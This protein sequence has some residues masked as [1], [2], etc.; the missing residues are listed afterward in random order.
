MSMIYYFEF[1]FKHKCLSLSEGK[2]EGFIK[3]C[4]DEIDVNEFCKTG[5]I[6]DNLLHISKTLQNHFP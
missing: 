4:I 1:V 3:N 2:I 6:T 5:N